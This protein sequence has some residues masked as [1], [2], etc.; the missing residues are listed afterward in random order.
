MASAYVGAMAMPPIFGWI[1]KVTGM[2]I[3]PIYLGLLTILMLY[4]SERFT[5]NGPIEE[6]G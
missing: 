5:Q 2:G 1:S 6:E 3:L 4:M